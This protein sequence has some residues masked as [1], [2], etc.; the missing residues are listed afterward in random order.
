MPIDGLYEAADNEIY[1]PEPAGG[2]VE[3]VAIVVLTDVPA[4]VV[5]W[6]VVLDVDVVEV[7]AVVVAVV[8]VVEVVVVCGWLENTYAATAML[9]PCSK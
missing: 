8:V 5:D 9:A 1:G 2:M 4:V 6:V 3:V 7:L